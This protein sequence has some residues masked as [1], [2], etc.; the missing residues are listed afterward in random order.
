M[1]KGSFM[2]ALG[3]I[4]GILSAQ[5]LC[6]LYNQ[7]KI[8]E[9]AQTYAANHF[10]YQMTNNTFALAGKGLVGVTIRDQRCVIRLDNGLPKAAL[11][12]MA[13]VPRNSPTP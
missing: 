12:P 7:H 6:N 8:A 10:N 5:L 2:A 4:A 9:D 1:S 3:A 13:C 11:V